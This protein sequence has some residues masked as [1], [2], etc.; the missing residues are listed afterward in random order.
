M[1]ISFD[2][3]LDDKYARQLSRCLELFLTPLS[4][5]VTKL[6]DGVSLLMYFLEWKLD[7]RFGFPLDKK[8]FTPNFATFRAIILTPFK[9]NPSE[10]A[11]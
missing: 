1:I 9:P 5:T 10:T 11:R 6:Y 4:Q 8:S 2:A 3:H 7:H